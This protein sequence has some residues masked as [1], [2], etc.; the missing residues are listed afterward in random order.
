MILTKNDTVVRSDVSQPQSKLRVLVVSHAYVTGVNQGKLAA[1]SATE[2][3]DVGLL[4]PTGWK[5]VGWKKT[6]TLETPYP[7]IQVYPSTINFSGRVGAYF[8]KPWRIWQVLNEFKPDVL[9]VEQEVFSISAWQMAFFARLLKIPLVIFGWEN[10][11]RNLSTFRSQ[12]RQYVLD[13]AKAIIPGNH[14]GK[15]LVE[16]WGYCGPIEV[17]PQIGVDSI[18]FAPPVQDSTEPDSS[19]KVFRIGYMGRL[20]YQKGLD[21]LFAAVQKIHQNP[22]AIKLAMC[23][24]GPDEDALKAE[25]NERELGDVVDWVGGVPPADVPVEMSKFDVLVLPSKAGDSW[26]EQFGHVLI[27]AMCM[28]VP[29]IGSTCGEI[30]NVIA[31]SELIFE[32]GNADQLSNILERMLIDPLWYEKVKRYGLDR[33]HRY[34][35]HECIAERLIALWRSVMK[36]DTTVN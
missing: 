32:E 25:A 31:D 19:T 27:E 26:K 10:M 12:V 35:T 7:N 34:Y 1:I 23:G 6:L 21:T 29:V 20:T 4:V 17:M 14:E 9:H 22:T 24:S 36:P 18:L 33:V 2:K 8:Y 3:A 30:P 13:T 28:G 5:A 16:K 11:D 15:K